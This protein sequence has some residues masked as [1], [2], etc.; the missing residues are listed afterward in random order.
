MKHRRLLASILAFVMI[1]AVMAPVVG[2]APTVPTGTV[3]ES[4]VSLTEPTATTLNVYKL[5]GATFD[6]GP[7]NHTG[8]VIDAT[9]M[10]T[11]GT[12]VK[13]LQGVE[14]SYYTVTDAELATLKANPGDFDTDAKIQ[15]STE[16]S[17]AAKASKIVMTETDVDG[18]STLS[19]GTGA[20][21]FI[22]TGYTPAT[23]GP[24]SISSSKAVPFGITLPMTNPYEVKYGTAPN[25][26]V[27]A[28]G[29]VYLSTV[30]V[31][32][33][34][35]VTDDVQIDKNFVKDHGLAVA[36]GM[37]PETTANVGAVIGNY[38]AKKAQANAQI[39]TVVPYEVLT[40]I[41]QNNTYETMSWSDIMTKGLTYGKDLKV[42][43]T[44]G[45][46]ANATT[47][48]YD[49]SEG[50]AAVEGAT[51]TAYDYGFDL[52]F[53]AGGA[54]MTDIAEK[55]AAGDV[56][57]KLTYSATINGE[58]IVDDPD[59]NNITFTP[60]TPNPGAST[61][62]KPE[63]DDYVIDVTKTW[64]NA[65]G[66]DMQTMPSGVEVTYYLIANGKVIET[67]TKT[68]DGTATSVNHKFTGLEANVS[69]TVKEVVRGYDPI[70]TTTG[71]DGTVQIK[72]KANP[73]TL[74]PTSPEVITGG[75]RFVKADQVNGA[76]LAGA[77]FVIKNGT[78]P[79][80]KYLV[81][82]T[83]T[84][85]AIEA[86][87]VK[88][89]KAAL[90]TAIGEYNALTPEQQAGQAGTDKRAEINTL[91]EAY[92]EAVKA[93]GNAYEWGNKEQAV[94]L[95]SDAQGKFEIDGLAYGTY[96]LEEIKAPQ[97]YALSK[98]PFEFTVG[99]GTYS[100]H[101]GGVT[102][103]SDAAVTDD[104]GA[105]AQKVPNRKLTIPQTGGI[106]TLIFTVVGV[107]L[108]ATAV[109]LVRKNRKLEEE[110]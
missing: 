78:G 28:P 26:T 76:R 56:T 86:E 29:T 48:I 103:V 13:A 57:I 61:T 85:I 18:L 98:D 96:Y 79:D 33:K 72:N 54:I 3:E 4:Q 53:N 68:S 104:E 58:A 107:A 60:G 62:P 32:P 42:T 49:F 70:Y 16:L 99:K 31:Y 9:E 30:N 101:A 91:Q 73:D 95:V 21:W 90:D 63:G 74:V 36:E 37:D 89:A 25:E 11:L 10:A 102:Y 82:K 80:A 1:F 59:N 17:D 77:E 108:M 40:H 7:W 94:V 64:A 100:S 44:S 109:L 51:Y 93:A 38:N 46:G 65:D 35:L 45:T 55:V 66:T 83:G 71:T 106:G 87:A 19:L 22:E 50:Q 20:Y 41:P 81:R 75:K 97:G 23:G 88:T 27:H 5:Q 14:F 84:Q 110:F 39:G 43:V 69:Y 92:N 67:V 47:V 52:Q 6:G 24:D 2:A 12:E 8:G 105:E 15:V 34:N